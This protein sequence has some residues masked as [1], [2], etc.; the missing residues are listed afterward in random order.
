MGLLWKQ[1]EK[2]MKYKLN[3]MLPALFFVGAIILFFVIVLIIVS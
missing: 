1:K 2:K 3:E